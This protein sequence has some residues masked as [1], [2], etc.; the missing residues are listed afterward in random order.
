M[1]LLLA[2]CAGLAVVLAA[3]GIYAVMSYTIAERTREIGVR[4]ALGTRPFDIVALILRQDGLVAAI[5]LPAGLTLSLIFGR[6]LQALLYGITPH[7]PVTLVGA[8]VF[9]AVVALAAMLVPTLKATGLDPIIAIR[10]E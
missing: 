4:I 7:D 10:Y 5:G 2:S 1:L 8:A 3:V 6:L 9:L